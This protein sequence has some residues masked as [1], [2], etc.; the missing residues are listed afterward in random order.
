MRS[1]VLVSIRPRPEGQGNRRSRFPSARPRRFQSAPG[2]KARGIAPEHARLLA[3]LGFQSAPGP[4]ARGI[5]PLAVLRRGVRRQFQSA[6]GPKARGI[7]GPSTG[8]RSAASFNPPPARRPGESPQGGDG[9]PVGA[10]SIRPRPEGQ[11]NRPCRPRCRRGAARFNPPPARRPGESGGGEQ[12]HGRR[13]VSIRPRPE[14][15]GN[16]GSGR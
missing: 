14:G 15:Q 5:A 8:P 1:F 7:R 10:V 6:P 2:P 11:G 16:R 9:A 4:K 13:R 12:D 3:A